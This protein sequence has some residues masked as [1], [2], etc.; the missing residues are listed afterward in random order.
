M[1]KKDLINLQSKSK[2]SKITRE[3]RGC[4][5]PLTKDEPECGCIDWDWS[6]YQDV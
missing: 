1:L 3:C 6:V 5:M 4:G 2:G